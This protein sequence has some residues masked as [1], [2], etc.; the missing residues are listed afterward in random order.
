MTILNR[1]VLRQVAI[2][3]VLAIAL[4][5]VVGVANE[6]QERIS[7][8]PVAQMTI[9]DIGRLAFFLLPT[10]VA[11]L[12]P[13][14][15]LLGILLSFGRLAQNNEIVAMKA[16]GIPMK[17][18]ILPVIFLG[19][20]LSGTSFLIQDRLQPWAIGRIYDLICSELPLRATLDTL[21]TGLMHEFAGWRIYI[22]D[23]DP[24]T[25][26]LKDLVILR[27]EEDGRATTYYADSAQL[28]KTENGQSWLEMRSVHFVPASDASRGG[29]LSM[30]ELDTNRLLLPAI[31][32]MRPP[33]NR[34]ELTLAQLVAEE[35]MLARQ[36]A[37]TGSEP[38]KNNLRKL[39][40]EIAERVAMPIA[41]LA[42]CFVAAPL[43]A[44]A[45]RSG[46]SYTF[47]VGFSVV[48]GY[49]LLQMT[50]DV[51]TLLPLGAVMALTWMP[52][53]VFLVAGGILVWRVDRV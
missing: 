36:A 22:G 33:P 24:D 41:C 43:G 19:A 49:Y 46:R 30:L 44:R 8:L 25:G 3:C 48:L 32:T 6:I 23:R 40:R 50:T 29:R 4:V 26:E 47:A 1:Y 35:K 12:V 27:P 15:Y 20:V 18:I 5:A 42:V 13:I 16:A 2:P 53:L 38:V 52:N 34:R 9:G 14:T 28:E 7:A 39:R 11:Y 17:R 37:E 10:L 31:S 45:K 51:N 21:P